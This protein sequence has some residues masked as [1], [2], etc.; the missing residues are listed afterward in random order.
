MRRTSVVCVAVLMVGASLLAGWPSPLP[1]N[2]DSLKFAV[3]GDNGT[4]KEPQYQVAEQ[5]RL[6]HQQFP[7]DLV[8]MLGDN[9]YG[10]QK[11][12]DLERKFERPVQGAARC[13]R[14]LSSR[15]GEP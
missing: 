2:P 14:H 10:S 6:I 3:I 4:G 15:A 8:L 12:A 11:P 7:Y 1:N 5:M 9:F 13:R